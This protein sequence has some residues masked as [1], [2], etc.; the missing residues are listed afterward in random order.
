VCVNKVQLSPY[1]RGGSGGTYKRTLFEI[2]CVTFIHC[3]S[4]PSTEQSYFQ[5]KS[6]FLR[7][8]LLFTEN[9]VKCLQMNSRNNTIAYITLPEDA[10]RD[11]VINKE[12]A[13]DDVTITFT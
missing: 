1:W 6:M 4:P 7:L 5:L 3:I 10:E 9:R 2:W 12:Q 11:V 8:R 13:R